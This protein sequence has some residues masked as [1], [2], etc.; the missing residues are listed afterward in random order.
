[1]EPRV[2]DELEMNPKG[3]EVLKNLAVLMKDQDHCQDIINNLDYLGMNWLYELELIKILKYKLEK[4][5]LK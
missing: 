2:F 4:E 1:M 3:Q 5:Q